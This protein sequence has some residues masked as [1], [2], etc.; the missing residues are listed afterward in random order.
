MISRFFSTQE[1]S[2]YFVELINPFG[3]IIRHKFAQEFCIS[4]EFCGVKRKEGF[5][6]CP[7][8]QMYIEIGYF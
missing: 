8:E 4:Q 7:F 3:W 6:N 1:N 2:G 5:K